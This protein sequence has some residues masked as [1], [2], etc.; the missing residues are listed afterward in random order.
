[1]AGWSP[2]P[3]HGAR[4][5][6][7]CVGGLALGGPVAVLW[8][9]MLLPVLFPGLAGAAAAPAMALG[10]AI[11]GASLGAAQAW[12]L[13]RTYRGL[14]PARWVAASAAAGFLAALAVNLAYA[15]I[16]A[17][18]GSLPVM[19]LVVAGAAVKGI[20]AGLAFGLIQA[21]V[22]DAVVAAREAWLR[23]VTVGWMLGALIGAMRW[24]V[25]PMTPD[26]ASLVAGAAVGG[27]IE[28]L[29]L[30]LVTAGAFRF[31]PPR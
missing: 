4:W 2:P 31:M 21:R 8:N 16:I 6:A 25:L 19:A 7:A 29:A 28:G 5:I 22:L 27:A 23:V 24:T 18:A 20:A 14:P 10:G 1:M 30:G 15:L 3:G 12:A 11:I 17:R 26:Q 13:A 9:A